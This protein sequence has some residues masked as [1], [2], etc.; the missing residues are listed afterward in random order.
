M[1]NIFCLFLISFNCTVYIFGQPYTLS[2]NIRSAA[3]NILL[4]GVTINVLN[5]HYGTISN[6]EGRFSIQVKD[7]PTK[8]F[9]SFIGFEQD[10]LE[11]TTKNVDQILNVKL[12]EANTLVGTV[13]IRPQSYIQEL[14][15]NILIKAKELDKNSYF[16]KIFYRQ[17]TQNN[18]R[19]IE[20]GESFYDA[21]IS[22]KGISK[23]KLTQGRYAMKKAQGDE[24][25][26]GCVN[27]SV[28]ISTSGLFTLN[29][30]NVRDDSFRPIFSPMPLQPQSLNR[31]D[32]V[33]ENKIQENNKE[34][35]RLKFS[36]KPTYK[37]FKVG[38]YILVDANTFEV[39]R[40][41]GEVIFS[42]D[43]RVEFKMTY[44]ES[45]NGLV[46]NSISTTSYGSIPG[47]DIKRKIE[48]IAFVYDYIAKPHTNIFNRRRREEGFMG[49]YLEPDKKFIDRLKYDPDFWRNNPIIA[50]TPLEE[51]IIAEFE[52]EGAFGNLLPQGT[53]DH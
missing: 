19:N 3:D 52:R 1:R 42:T 4:K 15:S 33:V 50:R 45:E 31:Y 37:G 9:F 41:E 21:F 44:R 13:E 46:L 30:P 53:G 51:S 43:L 7:L 35:L 25:L 23:W 49:Y 12:K 20:I 38:G 18:N 47:T 32:F 14:I 8:L 22:Y 6:E 28:Y 10:S 2:G 48:Q 39:Y 24:K 26:M 27:C 40:Y 36:T 34:I 29:P 17:I 11:I 16:G 5:S